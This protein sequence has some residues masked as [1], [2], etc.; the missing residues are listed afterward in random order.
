MT[1]YNYSIFYSNMDNT[2]VDAIKNTTH[3]AKTFNTTSV[4]G[5]K[6]VV[7]KTIS[8]NGNWFYG[9]SIPASEYYNIITQPIIF[10][11]FIYLITIL[12]GVVAILYIVYKNTLPINRIVKTLKNE[13]NTN[14]DT[15]DVYGYIENKILSIMKDKS[16][17]FERL[18]T[19]TDTFKNPI[20]SSLLTQK[21]SSTPAAIKQFELLGINLNYDKFYTI[22]I[23][24]DT[25][26]NLFSDD[27]QPISESRKHE[28]AQFIISNI[29]NET[30][31]SIF[32]A[33]SIVISNTNIFLINTDCVDYA[34]FTEKL[35]TIIA[36]NEDF[37]KSKLRNRQWIRVSVYLHY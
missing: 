22:A 9:F 11:L 28:Y 8:S 27:P 13:D 15:Y 21:S 33:I 18:N 1:S 20:L 19:Q 17:Y 14:G 32:D 23:C 29:F 7:L 26:T 3:S 25:P 2:S 5:K 4:K 37:I 6:F 31:N 34:D 30:L 35:Q 24:Y 12:F 10:S 16:I 36:S